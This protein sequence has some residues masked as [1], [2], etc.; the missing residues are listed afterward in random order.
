MK[1]LIWFLV[2]NW[3]SANS[4]YKMLQI[5]NFF[6]TAIRNTRF[7]YLRF[8]ILLFL[9]MEIKKVMYNKEKEI[10]GVCVMPNEGDFLSPRR[11]PLFLMWQL[12]LE[13]NTLNVVTTDI[14][15]NRFKSISFMVND[16]IQNGH[17]KHLNFLKWFY[18]Y[19]YI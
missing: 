4:Y 11:L 6:D 12:F 18:F 2:N 19:F 15:T 1:N 10:L 16:I 7:T 9:V 14:F 5:F 8:I 13:N 17:R 3:N